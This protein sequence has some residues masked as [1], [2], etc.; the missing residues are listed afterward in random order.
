MVTGA[1]VDV[2]A[3]FGGTCSGAVIG[4]A[5]GHHMLGQK[6]S[7]DSWMGVLRM[8]GWA[9]TAG[10]VLLV[11]FVAVRPAPP[12]RNRRGGFGRQAHA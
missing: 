3:E 5:L 8:F 12:S 9:A 2:V 6:P 1:V 7:A 10:L 4:H 11:V